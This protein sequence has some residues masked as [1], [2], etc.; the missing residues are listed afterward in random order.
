MSLE[1]SNKSDIKT[2]IYF[3]LSLLLF[4]GLLLRIYLSTTIA[5]EGDFNTWIGWG[6]A[7][8]KDGFSNFYSRNWC[9]YMPG[10]LY[11]LR[12]LS[13][14]HQ[15]APWLSPYI[16]F[17]LPANLADL[18]ITVLIF[19]ALRPI[20]SLR[21]AIISSIVYFFNPAALSNS[22]FWGQVDSFHAFPVLLAIMLCLRKKYILSGLFA[23]T[24]FMI[25]PQSIV[26]FPIIGF[27]A[28]SPFF[29]S[30]NRWGFKNFVP[31]IKIIIAAFLTCILI[32]LP[33]I[34][35][36]LDS[37]FYI[38]IEPFALIRERFDAAYDQYKYTSLNSFNFWG[39]FAMWWNDEDLFWGLKFKTW[40]TIIFAG[41]YSMIF[42]SLFRFKIFLKKN[43][44]EHQ[45]L[46]YQA[47]TLILFSLFLFVTR[48]HERHLLPSIVFFTLIIFRSWIFPYLYA[49]V[50]GVYVCNMIYSYI[51]LT[52]SYKGVPDSIERILVPTMSILYMI[53]FLVMFIIFLKHTFRQRI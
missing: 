7:L 44:I 48:A 15:E 32:S 53:S 30:L 16:L 50:S 11:V 5:F 38:F 52:T 51:Q 23:A 13:E 49:I 43:Y 21:I 10:Y 2:N 22:T 12:F 24:A 9:D 42:I 28:I 4:A 8:S 36:R 17:K 14:V 46:I 25:K 20:S 41:F 6:N 34:W 37:L 35:E 45:F 31:G 19:I 18:G 29:S 26:L 47:V 39:L 27:I 3:R 40:G 1:V 33:F